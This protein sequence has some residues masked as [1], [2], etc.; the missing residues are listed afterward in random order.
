MHV[1]SQPLCPHATEAIPLRSEVDQFAV[2][3]KARVEV[4]VV[5]GYRNPLTA[6]YCRPSEWRDKDAGARRFRSE[7]YCGLALKCHPAPVAGKVCLRWF[8]RIDKNE[9][10]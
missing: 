3:G 1:W 8:F 7:L 2:I 6:W 4:E 5:G 9:S 10:H